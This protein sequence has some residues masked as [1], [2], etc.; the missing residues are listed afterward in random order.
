MGEGG[1]GLGAAEEDGVGPLGGA[2]GELVEGEALA[3]AGEDAG[4]GGG[5]ESKGADRHLGALHEA[6]VIGDLADDDGDLAVLASHVL[7][8]A[9]K[10]DGGGVHLGHVKALE[11][12]GTELAVRS[13]G[14]EGVELDE[15]TSV[16]V[17]RLDHLGRALVPDAASSGFKVNSH[18]G[19][20][21]WGWL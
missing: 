1:A 18:V 17:L 10:G 8:E 11:D 3:A 6:D 4:A 14:E 20:L 19:I 15:K 5:G 21:R 7:R 9:G 16:G 13:A 12:G 2:E